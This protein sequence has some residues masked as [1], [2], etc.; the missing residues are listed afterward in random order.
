MRP[1]KLELDPAKAEA[2]KSERAYQLHVVEIPY[3]RLIGFG[4]LGVGVYLHNRYIL[5]EVSWKEIGVFLCFTFTYAVLSWGALY[6]FFDKATKINLGVLF[7]TTDLAVLI[8]AIYFTGGDRSLLF[9]LLLVRVSDQANTTFRRALF[10]SHVP[11]LGYLLMLWYLASAEGREISWTAE[12][13][14]VS[15][16]YMTSLYLSLTAKTAENIKRKTRAAMKLARDVISELEEKTR[17]LDDA[18][19]RALDASRAKSEFIANVSHELRTP[20]NHIIG[21]TEMVADK[22]VGALSETQE[23]YLNDVLNSSRHL[24][25]LINDIL[26]LSKVEAGKLDLKFGEVRLR[27]LLENSLGMISEKALERRIRVEKDL[28][29]VPALIRADE[30][31]LRQV[32]YN[33]LSNAVKFTPE[34]GCI[35]VT[36]RIVDLF[37]RSVFWKE[38]MEEVHPGRGNIDNGESIPGDPRKFVEISVSDNGIGLNPENLERIFAPFEQVESSA[39]RKFQGT[40]LGLTLT[41]RLVELHGGKIWAESEGEGKG[42]RFRILIP[43]SDPKSPPVGQPQSV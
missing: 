9:F 41:R 6:L 3:L 19:A 43:L 32:M 42:S 30:R 26:D 4:L 14:K 24:L 39:S 37:V 10:F 31:K 38:N 17:E 35:A 2:A 13:I 22:K 21:F 11:V 29:E 7:L 16:L 23:E 15:M 36:G 28:D 25:S 40:G 33:L 1:V 20:L 12:G 18:R 34:N 5:G 8:A 27:E